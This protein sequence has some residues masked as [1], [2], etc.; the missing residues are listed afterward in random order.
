MGK[1]KEIYI[2]KQNMNKGLL[3]LLDDIKICYRIEA[4]VGMIEVVENYNELIAEI[5]K[6]DD[7]VVIKQIVSGKFFIDIEP[8]YEEEY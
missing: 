6:G 8:L 5:E 3:N 4:E 7:I 2:P 1:V